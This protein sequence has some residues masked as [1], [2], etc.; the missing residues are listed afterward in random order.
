M[1]TN[2]KKQWY[3]DTFTLLGIGVIGIILVQYGVLM[4]S[5]QQQKMADWVVAIGTIMLALVTF[6]SIISSRN[7]EQRYRNDQRDRE[8]RDRKEKYLN[9]IIEWVSRINKI[10][11]EMTVSSIKSF[12]TT[13]TKLDINSIIM[14]CYMVSVSEL[15]NEV[16]YTSYFRKLGPML[17]SSLLEKINELDINV[18]KL[19]GQ[20]R[21]AVNQYTFKL[22]ESVKT[23]DEYSDLMKDT[24]E[25]IKHV[26][27]LV[28]QAKLDLLKE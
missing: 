9:E 10:I 15:L 7:R 23:I 8:G 4:L 18:M 6:G 26:L 16:V 25:S 22:D 12:S 19:G 21:E 28:A 13:N 2:S 3:K 24:L 20:L 14:A 27:N 1:S 5:S 17:H 11:T